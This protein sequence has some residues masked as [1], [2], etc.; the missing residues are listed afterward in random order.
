MSGM[1]ARFIGLQCA[2]C[3][4]AHIG[5][6]RH[7]IVQGTVRWRGLCPAFDPGLTFSVQLCTHECL[8]PSCELS[9]ARIIGSYIPSIFST[10]WG[11]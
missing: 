9:G 4:E 11:V 3:G 6:P 1:P 2:H 10:R 8:G 7:D 5:A